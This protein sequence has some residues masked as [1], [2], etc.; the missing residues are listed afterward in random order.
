MR[1]PIPSHTVNYDQDLQ[2]LYI[3]IEGKKYIFRGISPYIYGRF[4]DIHKHN[5]GKAMAYLRGDKKK[6][7][8]NGLKEEI[9]SLK[10]LMAAAA[11]EIYDSWEGEDDPELGSGGI[12]DMIS[13]AIGSILASNIDNLEIAEGGQDG[14]DHAF[15]VASRDNENYIVDIP[16]WIYESGGGYSWKK[17]LGVKIKPSD[18]VVEKL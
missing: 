16:Y 5:F 10:P 14:D 8:Q 11:Q 18:V 3:T 17:K 1:N 15:I 12:C 2:E 6:F 13:N 9:N 4:K 7:R